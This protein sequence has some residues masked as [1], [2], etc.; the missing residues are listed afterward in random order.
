MKRACFGGWKVV[1]WM[2][3]FTHYGRQYRRA[4]S[5]SHRYTTGKH[6]NKKTR[7]RKNGYYLSGGTK[8]YSQ[9]ERESTPVIS[10]LK[11]RQRTSVPRVVE[12]RENGRYPTRILL[13]LSLSLSSPVVLP[14]VCTAI[15]IIFTLPPKC[16][17]RQFHQFRIYAHECTKRSSDAVFR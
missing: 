12:T 1:P 11:C 4:F 8:A 14:S 15:C 16:Q 13:V 6:C 2:I 7:G 10:A 3:L 9:M 17:A 5:R